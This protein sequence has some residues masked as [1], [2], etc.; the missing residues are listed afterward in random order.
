MGFHIAASFIEA[1]LPGRGAFWDMLK[2][3]ST[4][5]PCMVLGYALIIAQV[6]KSATEFEI[7]WYGIF[8]KFIL[9]F[10]YSLD[11]DSRNIKMHSMYR[12]FI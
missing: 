5:R 12:K 11:W 1:A 8:I 9:M 4:I 10:M 6:S 7:N 3:C 2:S